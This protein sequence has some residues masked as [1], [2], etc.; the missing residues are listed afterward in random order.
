MGGAQQG[1]T[2]RTHCRLSPKAATEM[3]YARIKSGDIVDEGLPSIVK[4]RS[5]R[6]SVFLEF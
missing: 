2:M 6:S 3:E 5:E 1:N 4:T